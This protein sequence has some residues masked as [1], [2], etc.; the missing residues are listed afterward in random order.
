MILFKKVCAFGIDSLMVII[1]K[2][3]ARQ[4]NLQED[5]MVRIDVSKIELIP[6]SEESIDEKIKKV[7]QML[8]DVKP[9]DN[10]SQKTQKETLEKLEKDKQKIEKAHFKLFEKSEKITKNKIR[11]HYPNMTEEEVEKSFREILN[12]YIKDLE[13]QK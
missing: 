11:E 2:P 10:I 3:F 12:M 9:K 13:K 8:I 4:L 7:T 5:D 6:L 1:D